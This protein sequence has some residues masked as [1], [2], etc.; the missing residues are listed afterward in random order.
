MAK[1]H[2][3]GESWRLW[4]TGATNVTNYSRGLQL[5]K[6]F[7]INHGCSL[8]LPVYI[9]EVVRDVPSPFPQLPLP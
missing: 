8:S 2:T 3:R 4:F 9:I 6:A 5:H 1:D 7:L